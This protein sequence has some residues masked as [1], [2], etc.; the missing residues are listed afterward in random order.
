MNERTRYEQLQPEDRMTIA[1]MSQQRCSVRAMARTLH[2]APSTISRELL[3]NTCA[4]TAYGSHVAQQA[5]QAR[6]QAAKPETK[7]D[8]D[9]FAWLRVITL[10]DWRWS[11]QQISGTL[12]RTFPNDRKRH[13]SHE[14]IY[15]AIYALPRGE[16]RRQLISCLRRGHSTRMPRTRGVDRRGQIPDMLSIH[17][18]PPEIEDRVM[19]GHW[20]GDFI[21]GLGNKSS[22][23]VL[24]ERSS[25][26]VLL[27]KME[28]ATAASALAG[29]C[30]KLNS[31][32]EPMRHSLTYDQGKE[33]SRHAEL[34]KQTGV[35]I[36][37]CDPHSPWQ[38]GTCENTNGLLRQYLPKGTDLSVHSQEDL[39]AIADSLN[40]RPRA[41]HEFNTPLAVFAGMLELAQRSPNQIN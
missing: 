31:I 36:Y 30:A 26:L 37:F 28:D 25:R 8:V 23:G 2:R 14:T 4:G 6:R 32:A 39:D 16:L 27:A 10:L 12:K 11:P 29:F 3:R 24:V 38:R 18:R 40:K 9:G 21:K 1:S 5:C 33:M 15:T 41:T 13:V 22:V 17:V 20:E 19:P 34:R 7:L 35:N